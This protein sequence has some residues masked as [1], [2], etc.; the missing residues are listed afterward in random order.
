MLLSGL[1][2]LQSSSDVGAGA[3]ALREMLRNMG[4]AN[5]QVPAARWTQ[6]SMVSIIE[7]HAASRDHEVCHLQQP[8]RHS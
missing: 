3:T 1:V 6:R 8:R 5:A 2:A 4:E 7:L